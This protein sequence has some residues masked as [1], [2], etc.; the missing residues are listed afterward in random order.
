MLLEMCLPSRIKAAEERVPVAYGH[1]FAAV[2]NELQR[3]R[4][5]KSWK[6]TEP[7]T[8]KELSTLYD[9]GQAAWAP[10]LA[11]RSMCA[12]PIATPEEYRATVLADR[13]KSLS[14]TNV[15]GRQRHP[16]GVAVSCQGPA[17]ESKTSHASP[18]ACSVTA[19]WFGT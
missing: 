2:L 13:S 6:G 11:R 14:M 4:K 1:D 12:E 17:A 19:S 7:Y 9:A 5:D 3:L 18:L 16:R 15:P 10:I 8:S